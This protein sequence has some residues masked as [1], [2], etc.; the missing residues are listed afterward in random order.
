MS[1]SWYCTVIAVTSVLAGGRFHD[2]CK[3]PFRAA[4]VT[5]VGS[6]GVT[7][8]ARPLIEVDHGPLPADDT[9]RSRT[10]CHWPFVSPVIVQD[11]AVEEIGVVAHVP[12][13]GA[14]KSLP[15]VRC[16][17]LNPVRVTVVE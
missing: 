17:T 12:A 15:P 8:S 14:A 9:A 2:T 1:E 11:V 16:C 13:D 5:P 3:A 4:A 6:G 10:S 7:R